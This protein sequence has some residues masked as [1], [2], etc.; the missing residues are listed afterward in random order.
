ME[1]RGGHRPNAGRKMEGKKRVAFTLRVEQDVADRFKT[2]CEDSG[3]SQ[4][5]QFEKLV[6]ERR[7]P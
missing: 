6:G 2:M 1:N 5:K 7:K 4:V 3:L